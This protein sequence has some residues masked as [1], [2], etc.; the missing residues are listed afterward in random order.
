MTQIDKEEN[1][2]AD[3]AIFADD[4]QPLVQNDDDFSCQDN[5]WKILIVD[6]EKDVHQL[7]RFVLEDYIYQNKSLEF[8]SAYSASDA[9][10]IISQYDNIAVIFLDVVMETN[11]AG[12]KLIKYIRQHNKFVRI[13]LRTG[14]PGYAPEKQ[15]IL[16]YD[17][18]DY[19][20]KT[21]LTDQKLFT[22]ITASLRSYS[23]IVMIESYRQSLETKV[24]ERTTELKNKNESLVELNQELITLN[25]EKNEFLGIAA[26]D[27]KNPLSAIQSLANLMRIAINDFPQE[28][29]VEFAA[30]IENS[31]QRLFALIQNL[32]DV[33]A[34][35]SGSTHISLAT[36]DILPFFQTVVQ[37]YLKPAEDKNIEIKFNFVEESHPILADE[38]AIFQVLDNL[39]SNAIKYSPH[40]KTVYLNLSKTD[41][42]VICEIKDEGPGL[43]EKDLSKL[44]GKFARLTPRPTGDEHST[45][46]GLFIVKK[47]IEIMKGKVWCESKL[48]KG[49]SFI[50]E[51]PLLTEDNYLRN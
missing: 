18:N 37:N 28:K 21:E 35:E 31:A 46:L 23:D 6:D 12:L 26:H 7:T 11:D 49:T 34:I 41:E 2:F 3:D 13:I 47:L 44:F 15:V 20:N 40:G 38:N 24:I 45:G 1:I 14:Q 19:K 33:N 22:V 9:R 42:K 32:L 29:I 16:E 50:A 51:F 27:L 8:L 36:Y 10:E 48:G 43:N 25:Q 39:V 17:I 5:G 30:M 4:D